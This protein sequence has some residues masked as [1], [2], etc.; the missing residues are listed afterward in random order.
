MSFGLSDY[1]LTGKLW[2]RG[3]QVFSALA[4]QRFPSNC[5]ICFSGEIAPLKRS[6]HFCMLYPHEFQWTAALEWFSCVAYSQSGSQ[7]KKKKKASRKNYSHFAKRTNYGATATARRILWDE[8]LE[9]EMAGL[10]FVLRPLCAGWCAALMMFL[11]LT[12][13][14]GLGT[15][16]GG[17]SHAHCLWQ[18]DTVVAHRN[19][20]RLE[21][22]MQV[23]VCVCRCSSRRC[24]EVIGFAL[25]LQWET[26][27]WCVCPIC[28][29]PLLASVLPD[30]D[31]RLTTAAACTLFE[32][33][34]SK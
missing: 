32:E 14:S 6:D 31:R 18:A 30:V 33:E 9:T 7:G 24:S 22:D 20:L 28:F 4:T 12:L 1:N 19:E 8:T 26:W 21:H 34:S 15:H 11:S 10:Q 23:C 13:D 2:C 16:Y 5:I 27:S 3:L 25:S 17:Q 29:T